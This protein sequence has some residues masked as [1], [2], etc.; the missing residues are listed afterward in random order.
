VKGD[1]E[2]NVLGAARGHQRQRSFIRGMILVGWTGKSCVG[3][4]SRENG[5]AAQSG[6]TEGGGECKE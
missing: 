4:E 6:S 3:G 5:A 1:E 2:T